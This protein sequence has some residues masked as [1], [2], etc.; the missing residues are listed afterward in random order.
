M[1]DS[2]ACTGAENYVN[3]MFVIGIWWTRSFFLLLVLGERK[4]L[5]FQDCFIIFFSSLWYFVSTSLLLWN[6]SFFLSLSCYVTL[7]LLK[8]KELKAI[9]FTYIVMYIPLEIMFIFYL[10]IPAYILTKLYIYTKSIK[11][12]HIYIYIYIKV[13][14]HV[15]RCP[16]SDLPPRPWTWFMYKVSLTEA[17]MPR[18]KAI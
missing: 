11:Y 8:W 12:I 3:W 10:E 13:N 7:L 2:N 14:L 5:N 4:F 17:S 1:F 16:G 6:P 9:N 15:K 18:D